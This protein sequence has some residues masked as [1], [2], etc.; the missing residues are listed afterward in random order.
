[1]TA[2]FHHHTHAQCFACHSHIQRVHSTAV[3]PPPTALYTTEW[4]GE[5]GTTSIVY[6]LDCLATRCGILAYLYNL[7]RQCTHFPTGISVMVLVLVSVSKVLGVL[8]LDLFI[9]HAFTDALKGRNHTTF[10]SK[11]ERGSEDFQRVI[12]CPKDPMEK[13][14]KS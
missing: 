3:G 12:K 11:L 4:E 13:K 1:M 14:I 10:S 7:W 5:Q 6:D 9:C 8:V 2:Q